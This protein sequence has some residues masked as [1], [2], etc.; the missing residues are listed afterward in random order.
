MDR[1]E[2]KLMT[3]RQ[4]ISSQVDY[5]TGKSNNCQQTNVKSSGRRLLRTPKCARC[6]NHGVVSCLKGHKR[7]CRWRDCQCANCLLVVERQRVMAAQVALRRQQATDVKDG[8]TPPKKTSATSTA[9]SILT[10]RRLYQRSLRSLQ[11]ST[12]SR[13]ILQSYRSRLYRFPPPETLRSMLPYMNERMRKRRCFADKELE[14]IM[15]ERE[16]PC[17]SLKTIEKLNGSSVSQ[18][19]SH[20]IANH[21]LVNNI[22]ARE[23]LTRTFPYHNPSVL[24]LIWQG[25]GG[26]LERAIEQIAT[27]LKHLNLQSSNNIATSE[28]CNS[29]LV[30]RPTIVLPNIT[31]DAEHGIGK[32]GAYAIPAHLFAYTQMRHLY[33]PVTPCILSSAPL[34][35]KRT[36]NRSSPEISKDMDSVTNCTHEKSAFRPVG[37]SKSKNSE[38]NK[39]TGSVQNTISFSVESI[40]GKNRL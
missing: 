36:E 7:Y 6:R 23:F 12:L 37:P 17:D 29:K 28:S 38:I 26:N 24:E 33:P 13:E 39:K 5:K 4:T 25:C 19:T 34:I 8:K 1:N 22:N 20:N 9:E 30:C 15:Y 31:A 18:E 11:Q 16:R 27:G 35:T 10:Q 40:I 21:V 14:N 2:S 32:S 3:D